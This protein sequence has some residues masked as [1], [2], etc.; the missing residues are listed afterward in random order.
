MTEMIYG[1]NSAQSREPFFQKWFWTVDRWTFACILLL[2]ILGVYFVMVA[3]LPVAEEKGLDP[4]YFAKRQAAFATMSFFIILSLSMVPMVRIRRI[5]IIVFFCSLVA[6][7]L[8]PIFGANFGTAVRWYSIGPIN[9]QPTE[10]LK[11]SFVIFAAFWLAGSHEPKGPPGVAISFCALIFIVFFLAVQPDYG[12]AFLTFI[13]WCLMYAVAGAPVWISLTFLSC[14]IFALFFVYFTSDYVAKRIDNY[15]LESI[16]P[17]SQLGFARTAISEGGWFGKGVGSGQIK[18]SLSDAHNDYIIAIVAEENGLVAVI[19]IICL[20]LAIGIR[21]MLRLTSEQ[22]LFFRLAG[23][24]LCTLFLLQAIINLGVP[25]RA[26]PEKGITLPLIS[27]GGSSLVS[28][29][30]LLGMLLA[31][32]RTRPQGQMKNILGS[33]TL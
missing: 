12:Q 29:G 16:E 7:C 2:L 33:G 24:G 17:T 25:V 20:F 27:Y 21:T 10:L 14:A 32:T 4:F 18:H 26:V 15:L 30:F 8:L 22:N 31:I 11:P 1:S 23:F 13:T 5:A 6:V 19:L 28:V 3:S 9:F